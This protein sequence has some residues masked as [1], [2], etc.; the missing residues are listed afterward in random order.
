MNAKFTIVLTPATP[1][2]GLVEAQ[3]GMPLVQGRLAAVAG[4]VVT[5]TR[6]DG[7]SFRDYAHNLR[8]LAAE[9]AG[10]GWPWGPGSV[11]LGHAAGDGKP[12]T[13][14]AHRGAN[15]MRGVM[16]PDV[17]RV[18]KRVKVLGLRVVAPI[19]DRS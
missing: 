16:V 2:V 3:P 1:S 14:P 18:W 9:A 13:C 6:P 5:V 11:R 7:S 10:Y 8:I 12:R 4:G 15:Q 19:A 17:D